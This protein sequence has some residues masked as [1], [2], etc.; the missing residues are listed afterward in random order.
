M[1]KEYECNKY[2][3]CYSLLNTACKNGNL[4][5]VKY[6]IAHGQNANKIYRFSDTPPLL[7]A[8]EFGHEEIVKYLIEYGADINI[9]NNRG[10]TLLI[11]AC[12]NENEDMID[13]LI[14]HEVNINVFDKSNENSPFNHCM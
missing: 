1:E 7:L 9:R 14:D 6:L 10:Q 3:D 13:Y 12:K 5:I 2:D 11:L 8:Y 4:N